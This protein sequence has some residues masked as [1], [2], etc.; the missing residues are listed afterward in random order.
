MQNTLNL[1][2]F[3]CLGCFSGWENHLFLE[4]CKSLAL[5]SVSESRILL[6]NK[7]C[8][9]AII[10]LHKRHIFV[11]SNMI[12]QFVFGYRIR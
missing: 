12:F 7:S 10:P 1:P 9:F 11:I 6:Q 3:L 2:L 5:L 8:V 4:F